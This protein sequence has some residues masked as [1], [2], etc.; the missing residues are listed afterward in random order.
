MIDKPA[1]IVVCPITGARL[2]RDNQWR[3]FAHFGTGQTCVKVYRQ[4][5][6][7]QKAGRKYRIEPA[8]PGET[9]THIIHLN[10]GDQMDASGNVTRAR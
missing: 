8:K 9:I 10:E 2:C 4:L 1:L 3:E 6:S 5:K 7:A